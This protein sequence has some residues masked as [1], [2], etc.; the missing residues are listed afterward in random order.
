MWIILKLKVLLPIHEINAN[1]HQE[2]DTMYI[3]EVRAN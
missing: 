3:L 2:K 1:K